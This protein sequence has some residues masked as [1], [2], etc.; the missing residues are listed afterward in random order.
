MKYFHF[1][2]QNQKYFHSALVSDWSVG[3]REGEERRPHDS[4][5]AGVGLAHAGSLQTLAGLHC[6]QTG[7]A[8]GDI[9][10]SACPPQ[11]SSLLTGYNEDTLNTSSIIQYRHFGN[12]IYTYKRLISRII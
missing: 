1:Y 9:S 4:H 3:L 12:L 7:R 2:I 8:W 11:I 10:P 5:Q 6:C